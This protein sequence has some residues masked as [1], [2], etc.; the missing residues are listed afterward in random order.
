MNDQS[1]A[2]TEVDYECKFYVN[3]FNSFRI[4]QSGP[5]YC[6]YWSIGRSCYAQS[7]TLKCLTNTLYDFT[8][9]V[10]LLMISFY[11][12]TIDILR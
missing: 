11:R 8:Q 12:Y 2:T 5:N 1:Q 7:Y 10:S 3:P 4:F 9:K 6:T